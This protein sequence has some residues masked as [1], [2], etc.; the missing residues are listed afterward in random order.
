MNA[1][2]T[3]HSAKAF[4]PNNVIISQERKARKN[5]GKQFSASPRGQ[6][7][8]NTAPPHPIIPPYR[9][10][11]RNEKSSLHTGKAKAVR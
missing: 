2:K 11:E 6:G 7:N 5:K 4:S 1:K 10:F 3:L 8:E 9:H